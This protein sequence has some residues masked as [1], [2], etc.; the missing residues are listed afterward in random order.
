MNTLL[1]LNNIVGM[2]LYRIYKNFIFSR[3]YSLTSNVSAHALRMR[4]VLSV[5]VTPFCVRCL[6]GTRG[7]RIV[8]INFRFP[9][10]LRTAATKYPGFPFLHPCPSSCLLAQIK[11]E[12][13]S[14]SLRD[15][16]LIVQRTSK[17][18]DK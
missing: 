6:T 18:S 7:S 4:M 2:I 3:I 12:S 5:D 10:I 15:R 9:R 11:E 1:L 16:I 13:F 17:H 8:L 14:L